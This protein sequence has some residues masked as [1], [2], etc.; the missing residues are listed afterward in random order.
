MYE[1]W[2]HS[3]NGSFNLLFA[4]NTY[5]EAGI[6]FDVDVLKRKFRTFLSTL[7]ERC[8]FGA[9]I[10]YI[11][12]GLAM[13]YVFIFNISNGIYLL[14]PMG[15]LSAV[16]D[17]I[18]AIASFLLAVIGYFSAYFLDHIRRFE[19]VDLSLPCALPVIGDRI[20]F[21][22]GQLGRFLEQVYFALSGLMA[23]LAGL[24][25]AI[26]FL[27][28]GPFLTVHI[29]ANWAEFSLEM[30]GITLDMAIEQ[31]SLA[32][33]GAVTS[34]LTMVGLY[35]F[36]MFMSTVRSLGMMG[37]L[38]RSDILSRFAAGFVGLLMLSWG[39]MVLFKFPPMLFAALSWGGVTGG[40][41]QS[42]KPSAN[43]LLFKT[44]LV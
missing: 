9:L 30:P 21:T 8:N 3:V 17:I 15:T 14:Q 6:D 20:L 29:T 40:D 24:G 22:K 28:T 7:I 13:V 42:T 33:L 39:V 4:F 5:L 10:L 34:G 26:L 11:L 32:M 41:G 16:L 27:T 1:T 44:C 37:V 18:M 12:Q 19:E 25:A 35:L 38:A 2:L 36:A 31:I 23:L 43:R